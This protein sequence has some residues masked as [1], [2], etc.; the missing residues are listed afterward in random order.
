M[1]AESTPEPQSVTFPGDPLAF[2]NGLHTLQGRPGVPGTGPGVHVDL[3]RPGDLVA[4]SVFA[5]GCRLVTGGAGGQPRLEPLPGQQARLVVRFPFQHLGE[6]AVYEGRSTPTAPPLYVPGPAGQPTVAPPAGPG[7]GPQARVTPPVAVF[8]A[9]AS[10]LVFDIPQGD[11]IEFSSAG[12]LAA[13]SRLRM[14]VPP[15]ARPGDA[16]AGDGIRPREPEPPT[17]PVLFLHDGVVADL[18]PLGA[19][20]REASGDPP[21]QAPEAGSLAD[22]VARAREMRAARSEFTLRTPYNPDDL[23]LPEAVTRPASVTIDGVSQEIPPVVRQE[24]GGILVSLTELS[25]RPEADETAIEAPFRLVLSP[26]DEASWAHALEPVAA[27]DAPGHIELWHSRLAVGAPLPDGTHV[28]DEHDRRRRIVRA[29]WAR[30]RDWMAQNW[31]Q[32]SYLPGHPTNDPFRMSLDRADRHMIVR[33]SAETWL[34][35]NAATGAS[36][37]VG[38]QPVA[39]DT[40]WLS[41]LGAWL[42]LHGEWD[43]RPYSAAGVEA[44]LAWDHEAPLG[45]DQY[46]RVVYP[47]Y[48]YPFGHQA[49]LV[50]VTERRMKSGPD[51]VA[52][53]YQR[54]FLVLG[55]RVRTYTDTHDFPFRRVEIRP[56]VTPPLDEP[57][58]SARDSQDTLFWPSADGARFR[59]VIDALDRDGRPVRLHMPLMWVAGHYQRYRDID[60]AY[61][62]DPLGG[63]RAEAL[64][65]QI[66]YGPVRAGGDTA[67]PTAAVWLRGRAALCDST[68]HMSAAEVSLPAVTHLSPLSGPVPIAYHDRYRAVG[69]TAADTAE[70]WAKVLIQGEAPGE[71]ATDPVA[72]AVPVLRFLPDASAPPGPGPGRPPGTGRAGGIV[73]P[74]L[75]IRGISRH[76]GVVG[77]TH[78]LTAAGAPPKDFLSGADPTLFGLVKLSDLVKAL[79][80][81]AAGAPA[82][83]SRTMDRVEAFLA[84]L[85]QL[86]EAVDQA[87]AEAHKLVDRAAGG[88]PEVLLE[89]RKTLREAEKAQQTTDSKL[90]EVAVRFASFK[91]KKPDEIAGEMVALG[92][93]RESEELRTLAAKLPPFIRKIL[94]ALADLLA[95]LGD[96]KDLAE[97]IGRFAKGLA[98]NSAEVRFRYS[99]TPVL[100]TQWPATDPVLRL[101]SDSLQFAVEGRAGG[102][103]RMG[104]RALAEFRDFSLELPPGG[105]LVRAG[106]DHACFAAGSGGKADIDVVFGKVEFLGALSFIED[107]KSLIPLDGFADPPTLDVTAE[108][109]S[110]GYT[111]ALPNIALGVFTL[112]NLSL[113]ADL[114]VPFFGKSVSYGF[115]FCTRERPFTL[116]VAFIGGGGWL[117]LRL[118]PEGLDVLELGLEAGAVLAVD[119]GV[120]SGSVSAML[121]IYLRLEGD[122]GSL[123]GY[124]RMRGEL[125]VL[126]LISAS[127][128]LYMALTYNF[129]TGKMTGEA[130]VTVEVDVALYT[131]R[132]RIRARREF[133]GH[134]GDP[135]FADMMAVTGGASPAWAEYCGAYRK[136]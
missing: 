60:D 46:V 104:I 69:F 17:S 133:S 39:A 78:T 12:I 113:G 3:V 108:G 67:L 24:I 56:S 93:K 86:R 32:Q 14:R 123:T 25:C 4:L 87:V 126:G 95:D 15:L 84:D 53:L 119:L 23:P 131:G 103:G 83:V 80:P 97:D 122:T 70:L 102:K 106:F 55:E 61:D 58:G 112:S 19:V 74:E 72:P 101:A 125:D 81:G 115:N 28:P 99:W 35:R 71:H 90:K 21:T 92:F 44:I 27:L 52:G 1:T 77:E 121:G 50:K 37:V 88:S 63:R 20:V 98:Q 66:A 64:G 73:N 134:R 45:R 40:L 8:P 65:Q 54:K 16:R 128:E 114:Q 31:K 85:D 110:A 47:G 118:S 79:A 82:L 109:L 6:Q 116:A 59:F 129:S 49:A 22:V 43:V 89:A 33:Q 117:G 18:T 57:S 51:S 29:V 76:T 75:P 2:L 26:S 5:A 9:R 100:N 120:A 30:D 135:S 107:V 7:E 111:L 136:E 13:M 124:F 91:N 10:R 38:P 94:E 34:L 68:P 132:V 96:F 11:S 62:N 105:P 42:D 130:M 127:V 36:A 48:L 41:G